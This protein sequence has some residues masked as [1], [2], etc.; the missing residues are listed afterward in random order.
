MGDMADFTNE[1]LMDS[2]FNEEDDYCEE[3]G[4]KMK[5]CECQCDMHERW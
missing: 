1:G 2:A 3:C 5:D 4:C